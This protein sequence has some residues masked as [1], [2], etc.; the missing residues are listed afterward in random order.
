MND[1]AQKLLQKLSPLNLAPVPQPAESLSSVLILL[2][3]E[4]NSPEPQILLTK[5]TMLVES[6]KGE[7][8]FPGGFWESTDATLVDTALR[9]AEEEIGSDSKDIKLLGAL[10]PVTTHQGVTILPVVGSLTGPYPFQPNPA[11]VEKLLYLPLAQL[12]HEG[13][14][15]VDVRVG[16]LVVASEGIYLGVELIWGATAKILRELRDLLL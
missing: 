5:R 14:T 11:E 1:R 3:A 6:H 2:V 12:L 13:I 8:S 16:K 9:E 10:S 4:N 15:P 7:V